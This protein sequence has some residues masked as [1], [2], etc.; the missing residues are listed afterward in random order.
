MQPTRL[1]RPWDFPP[2]TLKTP[3][4]PALVCDGYQSHSPHSLQIP[5]CG[6]VAKSC[7]TL[8]DPMD[9]SPTRLL[10]PCD[11]PGKD[12]GV[13]CHALLHSFIQTPCTHSKCPSFIAETHPF[14]IC[15][16]FP[17]ITPRDPPSV[18]PNFHP[19]FLKTHKITPDF[20]PLCP[21]MEERPSPIS[22]NHPETPESPPNFAPFRHSPRASMTSPR[23]ERQGPSRGGGLCQQLSVC[24]SNLPPPQGFIKHPRGL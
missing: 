17:S 2:L 23:Q 7:L 21:K 10:C 3:M 5:F 11:S 1:L 18:T 4:H 8:C 14:P 22:I 6:V 12:T 9:C 19:S 20:S 24:W 15:P 16:K 13:D